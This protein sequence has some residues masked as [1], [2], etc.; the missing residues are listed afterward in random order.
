MEILFLAIGLIIGGLAAFLISKYKYKSEKGLSIEDTEILNKQLAEQRDEKIKAESMNG[1]LKQNLDSKEKELR[2]KADIINQIMSD[3]ARLETDNKNLIQKLDEQKAELENLQEKFTKEFENLANKIFEEKSSKFTNQNKE[4]LIDILKPL[5]DR[6]KDFETKV[7]DT[8]ISE[9]EQRTRLAT[10]IKKL[11]E[12]NQKMT[13]EANNLT[14]ALKGDSK[15]QGNWGEFI[16]ESI[17][18]KSGLQKGIQYL[19]QQS[20]TSDEGSRQKPD[21]IVHLPD[22]KHIIIDSKV[23]LKDYEAYCSADTEEEKAIYLKRHIESIKNHIKGLSVKK[24]QTLYDLKSLDFVIMFV[25][26][27]P[28]FS[29]AVQNELGIWNDAFDKNIVLISPATLLATLRTIANIWKQDSQNNN[30]LEIAKQSGALYDKFVGFI[31]DLLK[32]GKQMDTVKETYSDAMKKLSEGS[33]NIIRKIE[34]I[35]KLGANT[36][37]QIPQNILDRAGVEEEEENKENKL[38]DL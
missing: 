2:E 34:N 26:I 19:V 10:E 38:L 14:R 20:H 3:S 17:L 24:Y 6:I 23:S 7:N 35:K 37:K 18:E 9:T 8:H 12:L 22:D 31:E 11:Y 4:N 1:M 15:T 29:I 21:V 27:E 36:S 30:A 5:Q 33:G 28:A 13:E 25:P 16:L 32:V